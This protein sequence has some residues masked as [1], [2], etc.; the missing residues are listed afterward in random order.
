MHKIVPFRDDKIAGNH[1]FRYFG[2]EDPNGRRE[3]I[4]KN[5]YRKSHKICVK[6]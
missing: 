3:V 1:Y 6:G 5:L 4:H 2:L